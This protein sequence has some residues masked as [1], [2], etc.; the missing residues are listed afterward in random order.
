MS[1]EQLNIVNSR[2]A[3]DIKKTL[4]LQGH[5][6]L[7]NL[8][9]SLTELIVEDNGVLRLTAHALEYIQELEVGVDADKIDE[10]KIDIK[11]LTGWVSRKISSEGAEAI[12]YAIIKKWKKVGKPTRPSGLLGIELTFQQNQDRYTDLIDDVI[13]GDLD[14]QF[15]KVK[16]GTI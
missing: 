12:A 3:E 16:S 15:H 1:K 6:D 11:K 5:Y 13:V 10:S 2:I 7:G 9:Q 14:D 4:R 8:E